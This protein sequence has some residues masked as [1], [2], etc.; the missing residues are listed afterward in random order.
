MAT[1]PSDFGRD[2][3]KL[4]GSV[5]VLSKL[6][7]AVIGF[8]I[9]IVAGGIFLLVQINDL[10]STVTEIK[11]DIASAIERL[12]KLEQTAE[13]VKKGQNSAN[14]SIGRLEIL[15]RAQLHP[16]PQ[17][18]LISPDDAQIIR[19]VLKFDPDNAYGGVGGSAM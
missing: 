7:F 13:N 12:A 8:L 11:R 15:L 18:L 4:E 10:K 17:E 5:D 2:L 9:A 14:S 6:S 16:G 19:S 3:G 1:K